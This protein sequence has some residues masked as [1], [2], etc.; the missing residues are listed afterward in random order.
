MTHSIVVHFRTNAAPIQTCVAQF[1][2]A[3]TGGLLVSTGQSRK[4]E[5]S[6]ASSISHLASQHL[7]DAYGALLSSPRGGVIDIEQMAAEAMIKF[8][9][10]HWGTLREIAAIVMTITP[11]NESQV[12]ALHLVEALEE[13]GMEKSQL[14]VVYADVPCDARLE[15]TFPHVTQHLNAAEFLNCTKDAVLFTSRALESALQHQ[16]PIGAVITGAANFET[17]LEE[18]RDAE[19]SEKT[20]RTL[21]KKVL[22][23]R[24]VLGIRTD[25]DR[26]FDALRLPCAAQVWAQEA[27]GT[28]LT[29]TPNSSPAVADRDAIS[30]HPTTG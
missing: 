29:Q 10:E 6:S 21:A 9:R 18:A 2:H 14:R 17:E 8:L 23:Q 20:L 4:R 16:V 3:K 7:E 27:R 28:P 24:M 13:A 15:V 5:T 11:E 30:S 25:I 12:T 19:M 1:I 26:L 22:A